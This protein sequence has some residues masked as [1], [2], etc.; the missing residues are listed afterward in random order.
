MTFNKLEI[1][2]K[3][4]SKKNIH[5]ISVLIDDLDSKHAGVGWARKLGMDLAIQR[6]RSINFNGIIV[7]LDADT[8]VEPNY[9]NAINSF[10]LRV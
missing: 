5:L 7:G 2:S 9:L 4:Y 3:N 10:F 8:V 1:I 6:F